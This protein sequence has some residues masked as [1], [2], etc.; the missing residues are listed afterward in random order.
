M[1]ADEPLTTGQIAS[2]CHVSHVA[3]WKWI[4]QG[5]LR[6]YRLPGGHYRIVPG[7][8]RAFMRETGMPIPAELLVHSTKR[9]LVVD[10]EPTVVEII[11]R[12]LQRL[13]EEVELATAGDGFEAGLQVATFRPDLLILDLMMPHVDGFEVCR[14]V[15]QSPATAHIRILVVTAHSEH[16]N[17]Q[18]ALDAGANAFLVKPVDIEQLKGQVQELLAQDT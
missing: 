7:A 9:I 15:R 12:T 6:A 14:L 2:M 13:G 17:I 1:R 3:V 10:D 18:R 16:K 8:L 4:K 5:K 11:T